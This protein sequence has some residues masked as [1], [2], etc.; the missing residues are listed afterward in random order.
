VV[1]IVLAFG[2]LAVILASMVDSLN[3]DL[4]SLYDRI[5]WFSN[6]GSTADFSQKER[7]LLAEKAWALFAEHPFLGAGLGAT[8]LWNERTST[9]NMYLMLMTDFGVLGALI[10]PALVCASTGGLAHVFRKDR[11]AFS[12]LALWGG[13]ISHNL[14]GEHYFMIGLCVMA[15]IAEQNAPAGPFMGARRASRH[16]SV[17]AQ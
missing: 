7:I 10:F 16:S 13:M 6:F 8:E 17:G 3:L 15:A 5:A 1:G 2:S 4:T 9:H 11:A 14:I 12:A